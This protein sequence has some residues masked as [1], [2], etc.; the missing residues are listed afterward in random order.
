MTARTESA[1]RRFG[2]RRALR[3]IQNPAYMKD[4]HEVCFGPCAKS[5]T[6]KKKFQSHA[7]RV[8]QLRDSIEKV[9]LES[10]CPLWVNSCVSG[11]STSYRRSGGTDDGGLGA[12]GSGNAFLRGGDEILCLM[13]RLTACG[14]AMFWAI[15]SC[16]VAS[17]LCASTRCSC[18]A[19]SSST[20]LRRTT[21]SRVMRSSCCT[22][23]E[24]VAGAVDAGAV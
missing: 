2:D 19:A 1:L 17:C 24:D 5:S 9:L 14:F 6:E 3:E 10:P 21:R 4:T 7:S 13:F 22:N 15:C 12:A 11:L 18:L 23:S 20:L 16:L 8:P